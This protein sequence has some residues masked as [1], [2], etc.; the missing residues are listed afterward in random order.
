MA[1]ERLRDQT[2][3]QAPA[4]VTHTIQK[5]G[6]SNAEQIQEVKKA[7]FLNNYQAA[8]GGFL[9]TKL[10]DAVSKELTFD[11][12]ST[13][14]DKAIASIAD[15]GIDWADES[16]YNGQLNDKQEQQLA[17]LLSKRA[18]ELAQ[19]Y[20]Q[21]ESGQ[22]LLNRIQEFVGENPYAIVG[23]GILAAVGAVIA[24]VDL[25]EIKQ[26]FKLGKNL[27][28]SGGAKL[29][30]IRNIALK[31]VSVGIGYVQENLKTDLSF[32]RDQEG[33]YTGRHT[34]SLGNEERHVKTDV[35][36]KEE[37]IMA[38]N[39]SGLYHFNTDTSVSG[40][41]SAKGEQVSEIPDINLQVK[42]KSGDF[43]HVGKLQY[44]GGQNTL[45]GLYN[46]SSDKL[47]YGL[48]LQGDLNSNQLSKV[49]GNIKY[50]PEG[51]DYYSAS[52]QSDLLKETHS[53]D[54]SMQKQVTDDLTLRGEQGFDYNQSSGFSSNTELLGAYKLNNDLSL[55][56][57]AEY[58]YNEQSGG[59]I[60]PKIGI[61]YKDIPTVITFDPER[62]AV[63]IGLTL[64]F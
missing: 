36:F 64:R 13:L 49:G 4:E 63:S 6:K 20:L 18:K 23:I 1:K 43:T 19:E 2:P 3:E 45:T 22:A 52:F 24:D 57:G 29:G 17:D 31:S 5:N 47:K 41:V 33:V 8:L 7:E 25:P 26:K 28:I 11:K 27:S 60:L 15:A 35:E 48:M 21:S 39:V 34:M 44:S 62:K 46:G 55:I 53:L 30:S 38:Y 12:M 32:R 54:L 50:S 61:Q 58:N 56:G 14:A 51:S 42:T 10:Y 37:G 9:G 40:S 16:I 59:N